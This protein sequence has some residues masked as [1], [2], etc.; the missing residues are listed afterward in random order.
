MLAAVRAVCRR[1]R[2]RSS[3]R[4]G[5]CIFSPRGRAAERTLP[6]F[7]E[8]KP[9]FSLRFGGFAG[10]IGPWN[11]S[12]CVGGRA[13]QSSLPD[14]LFSARFSPFPT[15][16]HSHARTSLCFI[17]CFLRWFHRVW[18]LA[19]DLPCSHAVGSR[20]HRSGVPLGDVEHSATT[21]EA[22]LAPATAAGCSVFSA[23]VD[24]GRLAARL[25]G[26]V[27]GGNSV[28]NWLWTD[29][30]LQQPSDE[31][32]TARNRHRASFHPRRFA[33]FSIRSVLCFF[34]RRSPSCRSPSPCPGDR[35]RWV[36][37]LACISR[38]A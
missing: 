7:N 36:H 14:F 22:C 3:V 5:W 29:L 15:G 34:V 31:A 20:R 35:C 30:C 6:R 24:H 33:R 2:L 26:I 9:L 10:L 16:A 4:V 8:Y 32:C 11:R 37:R 13:P 25:H 17:L 38:L 28:G 1:D 27:R 21:A 18:T 12:G 19:F 23:K